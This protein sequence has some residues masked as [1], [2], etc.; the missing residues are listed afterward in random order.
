MFRRTRAELL[1]LAILPLGFGLTVQGA[2]PT[3]DQQAGPVSYSQHIAPIFEAKCAECHG[4]ET[5]E[6]GLALHTYEEVMKGSEYGTVV[7]A[8]SPEE[9]LLLDMVAA[10][11]MPQD[12]DPLPEEEIALIRTWIEQGAQNN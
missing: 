10:G 6:A 5:Q 9:S 12:R 1:S 7:E 8:G 11:E 2:P 3:P 4:P